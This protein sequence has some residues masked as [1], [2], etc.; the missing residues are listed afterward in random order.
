MECIAACLLYNKHYAHFLIYDWVC[1]LE[2]IGDSATIFTSYCIV[3]PKDCMHIKLQA[4]VDHPV[5][6]HEVKYSSH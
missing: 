5:Y 4:T 1:I 3:Q 6:E 2:W